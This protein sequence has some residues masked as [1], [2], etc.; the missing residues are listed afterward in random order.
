[1]ITIYDVAKKAGVSIA[2]VSYALNGKNSVSEETRARVKAIADEMG[3]IPNSLA[4]GL[5]SKK[6]NIMGVVVADIENLFTASF[7]KHLESYARKEDFYLLLGST[8]NDSEIENEIIGRFIAK[9]VDSLVIHPG[10]NFNE[11][12]F[13]DLITSITKRHIPFVIVNASFSKIKTNFVRIDLEEGQ[14]AITKY[15]LTMGHR[16]LCF[17]G[18]GKDS[19]HSMLK[20]N[21]FLR[22]LEEYGIMNHDSYHVECGNEFTFEQGYEAAKSLLSRSLKHPGVIVAINDSVAQG[23]IAALLEAGY[24]VPGDVSVVGNDDINQSIAGHVRLTTL[25]S[26]VDEIARLCVEVLKETDLKKG[27]TRQYILN[28]ELIVRDSVKRI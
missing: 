22:A 6:T 18:G 15:L 19:Y 27:I 7:I 28:Q 13:I 14:Y 17:I 24:K 20:L 4:Q 2:T 12:R 3:F 21:G 23:A 25:R 16:D 26:P 5:S 10:A 9:N 11:Q 8:L 1:M